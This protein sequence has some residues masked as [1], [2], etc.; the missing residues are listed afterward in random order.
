M[1]SSFAPAL[2]KTN[3]ALNIDIRGLCVSYSGSGADTPAL[4]GL[5]L[6]LKAGGTC[7]VIGPSGCG[8]TTLLYVLSGIIKA[9]RGVALLG[10]EPADPRRQRIGLI[11]Q[12]YGLL[13]W[14]KVYHNA[15]LG[16]RIASPHAKPDRR[17]VMS[18]LS[19]I[20]L[21]GLERKYPG[22]LSGGQRQRVAIARAFLMKPGVLLMDEAFSA[23]DAITREQMQDLFLKLWND[24]PV[25]SVI[26]THSIEEA[27]CLG[28]SIAVMSPA[29]GR[30][31]EIISNPLFGKRG[32]RESAQYYSLVAELREKAKRLWQTEEI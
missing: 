11:P 5:D 9:F 7:A 25:T 22:A 2:R 32:L 8:K 17:E 19:A 30:V 27:L 18:F 6:K 4:S 31:A 14:A 1:T 23:L 29:P 21:G 28:G 3:R 10:G 24:N 16:T 15:T 13:E 20:G 26:V 12:D